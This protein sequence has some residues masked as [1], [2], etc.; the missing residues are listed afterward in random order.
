MEQREPYP[1]FEEHWYDGNAGYSEYC[2]GQVDAWLEYIQDNEE[3]G[4]PCETALNFKRWPSRCPDYAEYVCD[5]AFCCDPMCAEQGWA[6]VDCTTEMQ[7]LAF[8]NNLGEPIDSFLLCQN[9]VDPCET[10]SSGC[11]R[12]TVV[13]PSFFLLTLIIYMGIRWEGYTKCGQSALWRS[14]WV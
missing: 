9:D 13:V 8:R 3:C 6:L 5:I 4:D 12:S 14:A 10:H 11:L 1:V 2:D 7:N